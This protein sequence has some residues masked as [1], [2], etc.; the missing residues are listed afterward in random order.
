MCSSLA[1]NHKPYTDLMKYQRFSYYDI[2]HSSKCWSCF[3]NISHLKRHT[4]RKSLSTNVKFDW[5][6]VT[7]MCQK[8]RS[9]SVH[10]MANRRCGKPLD[11]SIPIGCKLDAS[12]PKWNSNIFFHE[13]HLKIASAKRRQF[14]TGSFAGHTVISI[15]ELNDGRTGVCRVIPFF[16][17]NKVNRY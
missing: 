5:G 9:P 11:E 17:R 15:C 4:I 12:N 14:Y 8:T 1:V 6:L 16:N 3:R 7:N 2:F 10:S 13:I